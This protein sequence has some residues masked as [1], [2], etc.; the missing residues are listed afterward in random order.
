MSPSAS[1]FALAGYA[2]TGRRGLVYQGVV[3]SRAWGFRVSPACQGEVAV[4]GWWETEPGFALR[5]TPWQPAVENE[6]WWT[7]SRRI[8]TTAAMHM[9]API[10]EVQPPPLYQKIAKKAKRLRELGFTQTEIGS[11]LG[12]DRWTVGKALRWLRKTRNS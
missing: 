9:E 2:V 4:G 11:R 1:G 6:A 7:R 8:R 3:L 10:L 5:A 12:V